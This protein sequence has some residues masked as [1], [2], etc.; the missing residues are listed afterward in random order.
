M[1]EKNWRQNAFLMVVTVL[2]A[3]CQN[4]S[5]I[6]AS[7]D[8]VTLDEP[9]HQ[10]EF[11]DNR[12]QTAEYWPGEYPNG[13]VI[14]EKDVMLKARREMDPTSSRSLSCPMD[15][16]GVYHP[17]NAERNNSSDLKFFTKTEKL[18]LTVTERFEYPYKVRPDG[19]LKTKT[20]EAGDTV[21]FLGYLS[22]GFVLIDIETVAVEIPE[23]ILHE[24]TDMFPTVAR[25]D[26]WLEF[27]CNDTTA[28]LL[29]EDLEEH[30]GVRIGS[31]GISEYGLAQ[32]LTELSLQE[33]L[34]PEI[35]GEGFF[36]CFENDE[37]P[38]SLIW[39]RFDAIGRAQRVSYND[40]E[41]ENGLRFE[42]QEIRQ[43][44]AYPTTI[45]Y[46]DEI[47]EGETSGK[48]THTYQGNWEYV[49]YL[50]K[51]NADEVNFT[52]NR[53]AGGDGSTPCF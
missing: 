4:D 37:N 25:T 32:D 51:G 43:G 7:S 21:D 18:K 3:A 8:E 30:K 31:Y 52:I 29:L 38:E 16:L 44:A 42:K 33:T 11:Y 27:N 48:Y 53:R 34:T 45:T 41:K 40:Q 12:W 47:E 36:T 46:Y 39:I 15:Y 9:Q 28:Y 6:E 35:I 17:W 19:E 1:L 20:Y 23:S 2:L 22:E 13:I 50:G 10:K 14:V 5:K 49:K 26:M 24:S